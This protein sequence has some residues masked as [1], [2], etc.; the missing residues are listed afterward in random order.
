VIVTYLD[1][2]ALVRFCVTEGDLRPVEEAMSGF[3]VTSAVAAVEMPIAIHARFHRGQIDAAERDRL[4]EVVNRI[5]RSVGQ[6]GLSLAV[7]REAVAAAQGSLLRAL[8]AV[9]VGSAVVVN[10]LQQ[11]RGNKLV[12]CTGD[13]R[14]G[15]VAIACFGRDRVTV[16]PPL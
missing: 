2:S 13:V 11:R 7:R 15:D 12:F 8:D 16:L 3:P 9:H 14:Q 10:R 5:L 6:I 1:S 4:L